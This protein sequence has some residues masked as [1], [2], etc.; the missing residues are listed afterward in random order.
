MNPANSLTTKQLRCNFLLPVETGRPRSR[1]PTLM[2]DVQS[3]AGIEGAL[4]FVTPD[5][6]E[7]SPGEEGARP[8]IRSPLG[9]PA[10]RKLRGGAVPPP[11]TRLALPASRQ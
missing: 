7:L 1:L 6:E 8:S 11:D 2:G 5:G 4:K 10:R 3:P 9:L